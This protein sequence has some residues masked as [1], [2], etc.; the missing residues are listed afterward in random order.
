MKKGSIF[1]GRITRNQEFHFPKTS[2]EVILISN[3]TGIAPFLGMINENRAKIKTH[4]FWGGRNLSSFDLYRNFIDKALNTGSLSSIH[5]A[6]SRELG[7]KK[8][9][10]HV[11]EEN[12]ALIT[13]VLVKKGSMMVCGSLAMESGVKSVLNLIAKSELNLGIEELGSQ[14][15]SDC[16]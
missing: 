10:Q 16:Y 11:I 2:K 3:G 14:I 1:F 6:Y 15:K 7:E 12:S 8:Y 9:V 5:L 4:L 13:R